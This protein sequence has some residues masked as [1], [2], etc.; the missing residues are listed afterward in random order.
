MTI[1][2]MRITRTIKILNSQSKNRALLDIN[3][4]NQQEKCAYGNGLERPVIKQHLLSTGKLLVFYMQLLQVCQHLQAF[5]HCN[6]ITTKV[7][8]E[9]HQREI[10]SEILLG[11]V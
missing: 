8:T 10:T 11:F 7:S 2:Y 9:A 5:Q 6:A 1:S 4:S 3:A